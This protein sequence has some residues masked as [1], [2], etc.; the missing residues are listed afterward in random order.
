[1]AHQT[2]V[3]EQVE[4]IDSSTSRASDITSGVPT[5]RISQCPALV[6]DPQRRSSLV[7]NKVSSSAV[8]LESV[9]TDLPPAGFTGGI[10]A[11]RRRPDE[12]RLQRQRRLRQR[13]LRHGR[14]RRLH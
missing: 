7:R 8:R 10:P 6:R 14:R 4:G 9:G 11:K 2:S 12:M 5:T 13:L 1:M 3:E